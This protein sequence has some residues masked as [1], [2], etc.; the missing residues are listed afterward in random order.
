MQDLLQ[1]LLDSWGGKLAVAGAG[2][3]AAIFLA[4]FFAGEYA[5]ER[6]LAAL[7]PQVD[8]RI[9]QVKIPVVLSWPKITLDR[10]AFSEWTEKDS[11]KRYAVSSE[12]NSD[13]LTLRIRF[14]AKQL[15]PP[16]IF[17]FDSLRIQ[18]FIA[19]PET[20]KVITFAPVIEYRISFAWGAVLFMAGVSLTLAIM[21]MVS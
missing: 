12:I 14:V 4:G 9:L 1:K 19:V 8:L 16:G 20:V 5:K 15:I 3:L 21:A 7:P 17:E 6:E 11:T 2:I 18:R 13:S 10:V